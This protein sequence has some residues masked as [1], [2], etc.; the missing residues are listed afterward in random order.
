MAAGI[1][2]VL[3]LCAAACPWAL[4]ATVYEIRAGQSGGNVFSTLEDFRQAVKA[5]TVQLYDGDAV[6]LYNNDGSLTDELTLPSNVRVTMRSAEGKNYSINRVAPSGP[7]TDVLTVPGVTGTGYLTLENLS[8]TDSVTTHH[9]VHVTNSD[10]GSTG[11]LR[12]S[13]CNFVDNQFGTGNGTIYISGNMEAF[14][15]N[16]VIRGSNGY[17]LNAITNSER[18]TQTV[19]LDFDFH[20]PPTTVWD[21]G[22]QFTGPGKYTANV[23]V[24]EGKVFDMKG[25]IHGYY[26]DSNGELNLSRLTLTKTGDGVFKVGTGD[27]ISFVSNTIIENGTMQFT[28]MF[29]SAGSSW[30]GDSIFVKENG[31]FKISMTPGN[32]VEWLKDSSTVAPTARLSHFELSRFTAE[33][34]AR[35]EVHNIST[36]PNIPVIDDDKATHTF[37]AQVVYVGDGNTT[38]LPESMNI[39]NKLM[40]AKWYNVDWSAIQGSDST[41]PTEELIKDMDDA[42]KD[43]YMLDFSR[44]NDL[45]TLDGLGYYADAY[46]NMN[47]TDAERD[48]LDAIYCKGDASGYELG[49]LQTIGGQIVENTMLAIHLNQSKLLNRINRRL[50]AYQKE[51]LTLVPEVTGSDVCYYTDEDPVNRYAEL[52]SYIDANWDRT[53]DN[54]LLAGYKWNNYTIGLGYDWHRDEI[55][56]GVSA[57]IAN[58]KMS[59]KNNTATNSHITNIIAAVYGS[60]ARD[61]WYVSGTGTAGYGWNSSEGNYYLTGAGSALGKTGTYGTSTLGLNLEFGYMMETALFG[62][63]MRVTPYGSLTYSRT[64]RNAVRESGAVLYDADGNVIDYN[65]QWKSG[66]WDVWDGALGL[67]VSVPVDACSYTAIPYVDVAVTRTAGHIH[68]DNGNAFL[69]RDPSA[70]WNYSLLHDNRTSLRFTGGVDAKIRDNLTVGATYDFE[71]RRQYWRNQFGLNMTLGF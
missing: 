56:Y 1:L 17:S 65:K 31:V 3:F 58:G 52:W 12:I 33:D 6:V 27:G 7:G 16:S 71:W 62:I 40:T 70:G 4:A 20:A 66:I 21:S 29:S 37:R 14:I 67:R 42:D 2:Y 9:I 23:N 49:A 11:S 8:F 57:S 59:L 51:E 60:Y 64:N 50:T 24:A 5:G 44:I 54:E 53:N 15:N 46:R 30:Y 13:G 45:A 41:V 63:P 18:E 36:F 22:L 35:T 68:N 43:S 25:P 69:L 19:N 61:G 38:T 10:L 55:I 47:L 34:G 39:D 32:L 48:M 26:V 28:D